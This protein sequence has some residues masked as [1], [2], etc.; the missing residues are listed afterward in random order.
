MKVKNNCKLLLALLL[1]AGFAPSAVFA[2]S[3]K[4][5]VVVKEAFQRKNTISGKVRTPMESRLLEPAS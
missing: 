4:P 2:T 3:G 1:S 5:N